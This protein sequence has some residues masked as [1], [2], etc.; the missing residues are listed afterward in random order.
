MRGKLVTF[1]VAL[2]IATVAVCLRGTPA[3]AI[4]CVGAGDVTQLGAAG[5]TMGGLTFSDFSVAATGLDARIFLSTETAT[6]GQDVNLN[7]QITHDPSPTSNTEIV[8]GYT[9]LAGA[10]QELNGIDLFNPGQNVTV[11]E[12]ACASAFS[13]STCPSGPLATLTVGPN[14]TRAGSFDP[15]SPVFLRKDFDF[16]TNGFIS[17][18][19]ESH[20]TTPV[21]PVPEPATLILLGSTFAG[22]GMLRRRKK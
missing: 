5:C 3:A 1:T 15:T 2:L 21:T 10:G 13:G 7:F 20:D 4:S 22:L 16:G 12:V 18:F 17:E 9:V 6:I 19:T 14:S 11:T 8:L